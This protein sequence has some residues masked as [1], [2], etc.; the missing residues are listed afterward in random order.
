[1]LPKV[2]GYAAGVL[3]TA[4]APT[5]TQVAGDLTSVD[6]AVESNPTLRGALTDTSLSSHVRAAVLA[7]LLANKVTAVAASLAV[8]AARASSGQAVPATLS[9]LAHYA[10][11]RTHPEEHVP[12][13]LSL[14]A[15][16][17]RVA[18]FADSVLD[19]LETA[20]FSQVE[21]DLFRWARVIE[22][23]QELRRVL[24]D[25]DASVASRSDVVRRLL[26]GKVAP[27]SLRLALYVVE[28]GR[29]RDVIGSLDYLVDY[30]ARA[31][32]W[33]VAR[34]WSARALDAADQQSL[35]ASLKRITGHDVELQVADDPSLL[36]GVLVQVGD[37]RLDA[38][39]RGRLQQLREELSSILGHHELLNLNS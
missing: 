27:A 5:R 11:Q 22:A 32:D 30:V 26:E 7:D 31:R 20:A 39:T 29:P 23:N 21:D 17:Q 33:R 15:A 9:D 34:V 18:G 1:M 28:G 12:A 8:Y 10:N 37:L 19:T 14:M 16:R 25:R 24:V 13:T 6:L 2:E 35:A 3:A 4:D 36:G 38:T